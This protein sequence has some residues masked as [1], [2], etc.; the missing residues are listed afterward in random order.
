MKY[1]VAL[2]ITTLSPALL[3]QVWGQIVINEIR[4]SNGNIEIRNQGGSTV[5]IAGY[6]LCRFPD[7]RQLSTL[8]LVCGGDLNIEAGSLVTVDLNFTVFADDDELGLYV[9]G[10]DFGN[11]NNI[12][13]YVEWGSHGHTRSSVA[14][15]AGIWTNNDFVPAWT[16]CVSLEYDGSGNLSTDWESQDVP[17]MPC[18]ANSLDGCSLMPMELL[19]FDVQQIDLGARIYWK[20]IHDATVTDVSLEHSAD[21]VD[22]EVMTGWYPKGPD[23]DTGE[24]IHR[25]ITTGTHYYRLQI[26]YIDGF[27]ESSQIKLLKICSDTPEM[28]IAP[29]PAQNRITVYVQTPEPLEMIEYRILNNQ[30]KVILLH[31]GPPITEIDLSG[32]PE[33]IYFLQLQ[34]FGIV[35]RLIRI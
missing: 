28:T 7:Y 29:N 6:F 27:T 5:N 8:T 4:A 35:Q 3:Y 26:R 24:F 30:G 33:G 11:P 31:E 13:D 10:S 18:I 23:F 14:E 20:A 17:T 32:I 2:L 22:W 25:N 34:R 9:N 1:I 12:R 15:A 16:D 19:A 21:Q